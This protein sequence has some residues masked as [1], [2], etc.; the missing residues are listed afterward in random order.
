MCLPFNFISQS[1]NTHGARA[2]ASQLQPLSSVAARA[3]GPGQ[4]NHILVQQPVKLRVHM[5]RPGAFC[6]GSLGFVTLKQRRE[7][8][9][10][11]QDP[12]PLDCGLGVE[13][14]Y[15]GVSTSICRAIK[16]HIRGAICF[17]TADNARNFY[18]VLSSPRIND[19]NNSKL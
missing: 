12:M 16:K 6:M 2:A 1:V 8:P 15:R 4:N 3:K 11:R 18:H 9:R 10:T 13:A 17:L 7:E 19:A 14:H 5:A